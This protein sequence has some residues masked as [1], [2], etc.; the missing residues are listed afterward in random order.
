MYHSKYIQIIVL[1]LVCFITLTSNTFA[2]I[3]YVKSQERFE[4][5]DKLKLKPG[6]QILLKKGMKFTGSLSIKASGSKDS[7]IQIGSYG[8]GTKPQI[9][10]EGRHPA[11]LLLTDP[12]FIEVS[13]LEITN[14]DGSIKDQGEL[15]GIYV[16]A[17]GA[18]KTYKHVHI[19]DCFIHDVNGQVAGKS[20]G[21]IHVHMKNLK[22]SKFDDLRITNNRIVD[23]GGVGIGNRSSCADVELLEDETVT[24]NLWTKVYVAGNFVDKTGRNNII[25]RVSKDA[26]YEYNTLANS[27]L[28]DTGHSIFCFD[29]VGIKIQYNEA[30][31]NV[32]SEGKD[33][34]G[35]DADYSCDN[36]FIQYNYSHD[37]E[38]FC[39][40]MKKPNRNITIRYNISINDKKGI[41]FYGFDSRKE[42]ENI[43]I[44]NNTHFIGKHLNTEVFVEGRTPYDSTFENNIFYFEGT[45]QWGKKAK[46]IKTSFNNNLY[47][48][49]EPH[50]SDK[51][52][53]KLD[54]KFI[55][56]G[57][58]PKHVDWKSLQQFKGYLLKAGSPALDAGVPIKDN[59]GINFFRNKLENKTHLGAT[60]DAN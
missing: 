4:A 14:T 28:Y 17:R 31:G 51:S 18:E 39:G 47:Y 29:T 36:T 60:D 13:G 34:G 3:Y 35:F 26:I 54:P 42:A 25:A 2:K 40:I 22:K 45:G 15:F 48:G 1:S 6:D 8:E 46:G 7:P 24:K 38:W 57:K 37:N 5:V 20:R 59:G 32:G 56:S 9:H 23:V 49:I 10:A 41:Y 12:S 43:H 44:Y 53:I 52:P 16:I 33:R 30:Y 50:P 19:N 58:T 11:G 21:G 27:S 55:S